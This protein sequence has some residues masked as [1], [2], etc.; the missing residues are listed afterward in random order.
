[1]A[2]QQLVVA[3]DADLARSKRQAEQTVVTAEADSRQRTLAGRGEAQRVIQIGLSEATVLLRKIAS[4]GD[5]RL[6]ALAVVAEQMAH[7]SQPLVP[8]RVFV[9]SGGKED[10]TVGGAAGMLGLLVSLLVGEKS[11]FQ[12]TD[13]PELGNL[14]ELSDRITREALESLQQPAA[15]RDAVAQLLQVA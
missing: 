5:P 1:L 4:F 7:S 3:A 9:A 13:S 11:G 8:E 12:L 10:G 15:A 14:K 2:A 6:Y